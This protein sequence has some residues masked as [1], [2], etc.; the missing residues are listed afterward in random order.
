MSVWSPQVL[1]HQ[2]HSSARDK[3]SRGPPVA[4]LVS[5]L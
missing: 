5:D 2:R 4:A 1:A 3:I